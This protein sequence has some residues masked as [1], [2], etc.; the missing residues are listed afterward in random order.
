MKKTLAGVVLAPAAVLAFAGCTSAPQFT[1]FH[2]P[3]GGPPAPVA[4]N[5]FLNDVQHRLDRPLDNDVA[6]V[7]GAMAGVKCMTYTSPV[8]AG[9]KLPDPGTLPASDDDRELMRTAMDMATPQSGLCQAAKAKQDRDDAEVA[10]T[11]ARVDA[12]ARADAAARQ[13]AARKEAAREEA[14]RQT[15]EQS[16]PPATK[17]SPKQQSGS[18]T[19]KPYPGYRE[20]IDG[21][22]NIGPGHTSGG[23]AG[24][25]NPYSDKNPNGQEK[26]SGQ[27][28]QEWNQK[29]PQQKQ[30]QR[31]QYERNYQKYSSGN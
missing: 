5:T 21:N 15:T 29:S 27:R 7:A 19:S 13:E 17:S 14:Q 8:M 25:D 26:S 9:M 16:S 28:Q 12:E 10:A 30:S 11:R 20:G 18:S 2:Q 6:A 24:S 1:Q 3:R 23:Y 22:K 31:E 4:E